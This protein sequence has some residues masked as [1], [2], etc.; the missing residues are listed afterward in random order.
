VVFSLETD[1]PPASWS[2][3]RQRT[4]ASRPP[5]PL[6]MARAPGEWIW[7]SSWTPDGKTLVLGFWSAGSS[8]DIYYVSFDNP[9][10]LRPFLATEADELHGLLSPDGH[11]IAY[12]SNETGRHAIYVQRFPDG[13]ARHQISAG[14]VRGLVGWQP[15]GR[16]IYYVSGNQM[17]ME[18]EIDTT[19]NLR[20][21]TPRALFDVS[22]ESGEWFVPNLHLSGDGKRF[23][24][25]TPDEEWGTATEIKVILNWFQGGASR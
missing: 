5:E 22:Y 13:G 17:I 2:I 3:F 12:I 19:S 18:V 16:K 4:D 11:W 9:T 21:A 10:D 20:A 8:R 25:V 23:V 15:D 6:V 14:A 7:P 24:M 1:E